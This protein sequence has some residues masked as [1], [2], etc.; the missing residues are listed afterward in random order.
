[1]KVFLLKDL[2]H[3]GLSGEIVKVKEGFAQNYLFP[4]KLA[5]EVNKTN[6]QHFKNRERVVDHRKEVLESKTSMLAEKIK[7]TSI[8]LKRKTHDDGKLYGSINPQE[9]VD[10]LG[11]KGIAISK[12]Q[13]LFGKSIKTTGDYEITIKLS[14]KL[15]PAVSLKVVP[16]AA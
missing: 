3:I 6:Q 13:V 7:S 15:Q 4:R 16:A 11:E 5:V 14:S 9:I 8:T 10:L 12:S 1:M 2:E